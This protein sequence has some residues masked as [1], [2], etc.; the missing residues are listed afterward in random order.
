M[1]MQPAPEATMTRNR[2]SGALAV[3][4]VLTAGIAVPVAAIGDERGNPS[5][6]IEVAQ[7][8]LAPRRSDAGPSET[9]SEVREA[10]E[11]VVIQYNPPRRGS[12]RGR[13]GAGLRGATAHPRPLA[14][15]PDHVAET[16][17]AQPSLFWH[18][19]GLPRGD[20]ELI[21]TLLDEDALDP[22]AEARLARPTGAGI[23][24]VR[25]ADLGVSL[26]PDR[27]YEWS[28][29]LVVD[30]GPRS[31]DA[32]TTGYIRRVAEPLELAARAPDVSS[33]AE[34]GLWYDALESVSDSIDAR[35]LDSSLREQRSALLRQAGLEP[36]LD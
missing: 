11:P 20:S 9:H 22:V 21:F 26:R 19:D 34:L 32:V 14:L 25:L 4:V 13:V 10:V 12:P 15:A 6:E 24:R 35:P 23:Q 28:I 30:S 16:V 8:R 33:Y 1:S 18:I 29:S 31:H 36:A 7:A 5:G 2:I 27:E 3:F 17:S